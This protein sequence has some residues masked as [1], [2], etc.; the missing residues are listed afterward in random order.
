MFS[1]HGGQIIHPIYIR[2]DLRKRQCFGMFLETAVKVA[3]VRFTGFY[4]FALHK[5]LQPENT[6]GRRMLRAKV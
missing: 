5:E 2:N 4:Q 1:V 3:Y 6:M